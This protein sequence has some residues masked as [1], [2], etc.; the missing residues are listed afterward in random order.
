MCV[1]RGL[2]F[3]PAASLPLPSLHCAAHARTRAPSR[4]H[5]RRRVT[6]TTSD[7]TDEA[8]QANIVAQKYSLA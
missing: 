7:A 8:V 1:Q 2:P 3:P 5:C 4:A 6:G